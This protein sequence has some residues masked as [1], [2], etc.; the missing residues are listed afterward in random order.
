MFQKLK[1]ESSL[2]F[3]D[4]V[5][6]LA[7]GLILIKHHGSAVIMDASVIALLA[8]L[9]ARSFQTKDVLHAGCVS[10]AGLLILLFP[11]TSLLLAIWPVLLPRKPVFFPIIFAALVQYLGEYFLVGNLPFTLGFSM[12]CVLV[13][14]CLAAASQMCRTVVML[15]LLVSCLVTTSAELFRTAKRG[16]A[17]AEQID[18][19]FGYRIGATASRVANLEEAPE[20][21]KRPLRSLLKGDK[22]PTDPGSIVLLEHDQWDRHPTL[23]ARENWH[24]REPWNENQ[25]LGCQFWLAAI[26]ADRQ[27]QSNLGGQAI[28]SGQV[29]LLSPEQSFSRECLAVKRD[30]IL[31]LGDSDYFCNGMSAYQPALL[32]EILVVPRQFMRI[33]IFSILLLVTGMLVEIAVLY[34]LSLSIPI[35]ALSA[36]FFCMPRAVNGDVRINGKVFDPHEPSRAS[37]VMGALSDGG[38]AAI[39]GDNGAAMLVVAEGLTCRRK[40]EA[41][42]ILEPG[43]RVTIGPAVVSADEIP[44]GTVADVVDAR[45]LIIDGQSSSSVDQ[46]VNGVRVV[47]TGS[48]SKNVVRLWPKH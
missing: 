11:E 6:L 40:E 36:C 42:V 14:G 35:V 46:V 44:L 39:R 37:G 45:H 31:Y 17:F 43:S 21:S 4:T 27:F 47:G 29:L 1:P 10:V 33:R 23:A 16:I 15:G 28:A 2:F 32:S 3:F 18:T 20:L 9:L 7:A 8:T 19:P 30:D 34:P 22:V 25:L 13:G 24:Q 41:V 26:K 48:P 38:I 5:A 12:T